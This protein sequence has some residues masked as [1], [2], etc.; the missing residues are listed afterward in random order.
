M[1]SP[2]TGPPGKNSGEAG[3]LSCP[4][5]K[6]HLRHLVGKLLLPEKCSTPV[7]IEKAWTPRA[8]PKIPGAITKMPVSFIGELSIHSSINPQTMGTDLRRGLKKEKK[9][10]STHRVKGIVGETNESAGTRGPQYFKNDAADLKPHGFKPQKAPALQGKGSGKA[11]KNRQIL[12]QGWISKKGEGG[13]VA[14]SPKCLTRN[15]SGFDLF[16]GARKV[17]SACGRYVPLKV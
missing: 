17:N 13:V 8:A 6:S 14:D 15:R 2:L 7:C 16:P 1:K 9:N 4:L 12:F 5:L 10:R 3:N 11:V